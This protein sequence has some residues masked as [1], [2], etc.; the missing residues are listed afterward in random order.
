M[1][2]GA[3]NIDKLRYH[4]VI[5]MTDADVDGA[6]IRTLILTFFYRQYQQLVEQGY[7][8]IAQP[9]LY[10]MHKDS[11]ERYIKNEEEMNDFLVRRA[12]EELALVRPDG[13]EIRG[14]KLDRMLRRILALRELI[15]DVA[16]M[17]VPESLYRSGLPKRTDGRSP[18]R[19]L[20]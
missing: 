11:F 4:R 8:Y 1:V 18:T 10:R 14:K 17:G 16:G 5:I 6:H 2:D 19:S 20:K 3:L 9:P 13:E 15:L 12:A 7:L